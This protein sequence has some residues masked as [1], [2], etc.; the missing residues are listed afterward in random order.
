MHGT[1][2][3]DVDLSHVYAGALAQG[4]PI[5]RR[6]VDAGERA[7]G[8]QAAAAR[9]M[10]GCASSPPSPTRPSFSGSSNIEIAQAPT[11][12]MSFGAGGR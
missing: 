5:D 10:G 4:R 3:S 7:H 1:G 2:G 6:Q 11:A 12:I 9:A 8:L